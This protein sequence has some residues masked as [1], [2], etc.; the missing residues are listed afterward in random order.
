[1]VIEN[2]EKNIYIYRDL[3]EE[4]GEKKLSLSTNISCDY[5]RLKNWKIL[6]L[7]KSIC[8]EKRYAKKWYIYI[9]YSLYDNIH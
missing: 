1:M 7:E 9:C 3:I 4:R 6:F 2:I 5:I 8:S